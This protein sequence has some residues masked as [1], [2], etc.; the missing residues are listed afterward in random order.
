M[1]TALKCA[2]FFMRHGMDE[3]RDTFDGNMKLQ[4]MLL[5]ADLISMA[6]YDHP[7]FDD[8]ICA[9]ANGCVVESVRLRYKNDFAGLLKD[10]VEF[11]PDFT[12]EEYDSLN[13]SME[14]FGHLSAKELSDLNHT[15]HF[16]EKYFDASKQPDG[17]RSKLESI[18]PK[19]ALKEESARIAE[20]IEIYQQ[21]K[22]EP[23]IKET[24]NGVDFY[25]DPETVVVDDA[26]MDV[27]FN[28]SLSADENAYRVYSEDGNLVIY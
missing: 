17:Y 6:Q 23:V 26:L 14:I 25:C 19:S 7:L 8:N 24:V 9:F 3:R 5:F 11:D 16:W 2:K 15:F 4:K 12:Q 21:D 27:L 20:I 18:I 22:N 10:S 28:F 13:L 1:S